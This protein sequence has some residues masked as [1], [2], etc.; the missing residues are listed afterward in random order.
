[1]SKIKAGDKVVRDTATQNP[2]TVK[3]GDASPVFVPA[4]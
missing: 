2:S 3:L 4:R 1:M